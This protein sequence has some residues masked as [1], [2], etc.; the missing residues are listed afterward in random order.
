M[1]NY[2]DENTQRTAALNTC[3]AVHCVAVA[4]V[5][6]FCS[7]ILAQVIISHLEEVE[8]TKGNNGDKG[9]LYITNLRAIWLSAE[10]SRINL[11]QCQTSNSGPSVVISLLL[12]CS[13]DLF[14]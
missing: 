1:H 10:L 13:F 3:L 9:R 14:F 12:S 6:H 11:S 7:V 2:Y 5:M 8:D 4:T